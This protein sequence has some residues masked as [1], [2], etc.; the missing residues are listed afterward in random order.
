M[1]M[2]SAVYSSEWWNRKCRMNTQ[3]MTLGITFSLAFLCCHTGGLEIHHQWVPEGVGIACADQ[4]TCAAL[5]WTKPVKRSQ[6]ENNFPQ[7][8]GQFISNHFS[9]LVFC[10]V[11]SWIGLSQ[12][13]V[14]C[15]GSRLGALQGRCAAD[16]SARWE[17]GCA[18]SA[19]YGGV[20]GVAA[21]GTAPLP[22]YP[23]VL[24]Q[25]DMLVTVP[26]GWE[27]CQEGKM[28]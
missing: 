14:S 22:S 24:S 1:K 5:W 8:K 13:R 4:L 9:N 11:H 17:D 21:N 19:W 15:L 27:M 7:G 20:F 6:L 26:H 12:W 10:V 3:Y 2:L 18:W 25:C 16:P 23:H 28:L